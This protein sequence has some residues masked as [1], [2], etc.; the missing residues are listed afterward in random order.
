MRVAKDAVSAERNDN[1][2]RIRSISSGSTVRL[3]SVVIR[4]SSITFSA[5]TAP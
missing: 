4:I 1:R 5:I 2:R 3:A